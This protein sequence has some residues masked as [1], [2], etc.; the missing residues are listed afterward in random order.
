MSAP[1]WLRPAARVLLALFFIGAGLNHFVSPEIY[2]AMMPPWL[3]LPPAIHLVAGAAEAL[4]GL[5]L[6]LPATRRLAAG[7]LIALL[8]AIFPAN[9]H[10]ALSAEMPG[11]DLPGWVLWARLPLQAVFIAVVAWATP[12]RRD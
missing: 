4:G 7:G 5:G 12:L 6:L 9:V 8:I 10:V 2:R 3:P 1:A 11:L